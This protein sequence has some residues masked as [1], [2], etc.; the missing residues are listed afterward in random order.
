VDLPRRGKQIWQL[1][2]CMRPGASTP[3]WNEYQ[4]AQH[5]WRGSCSHYYH[6]AHSQHTGPLHAGKP[7][8]FISHGSQDNILDIELTSRSEATWVLDCISLIF[9]CCGNG[10]QGLRMPIKASCVAQMHFNGMLL[11]L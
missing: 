5:A 3:T 11:Q 10:V 1:P 8:V 9:E 6:C 2:T 4:H 7:A